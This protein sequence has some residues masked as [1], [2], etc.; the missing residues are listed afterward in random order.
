MCRKFYLLLSPSALMLCGHF[1]TSV[2]CMTKQRGCSSEGMEEN[3]CA[4][5]IVV[6]CHFFLLAIVVSR[7]AVHLSLK[8]TAISVQDICVT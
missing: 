7:S 6:N 4:S 8:G 3:L 2:T 5:Y 1:N